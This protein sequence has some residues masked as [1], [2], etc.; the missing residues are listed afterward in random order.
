MKR[1]YILRFLVGI[2]VVATIKELS[3]Q[4][5]K[6]NEQF[7]PMKASQYLTKR[8]VEIEWEEV[9]G[10]T[11]YDLEIY[12]GKNKRFI[13]TFTSKTNVF[14]LNVKMG[15][16]YFRSRILDKFERSSEWTDLAELMIAP[17]PTKV[18]TKFPED[19]HL[20]ADKKSGLLSFPLSWE[21]LPGISDYQVVMQSPDGKIESEKSVTGTSTILNVPPGQH[22]FYVKAVLSDGTIGDKSDNTSTISVLGAKIQKPVLIH[23][24]TID[25]GHQAL[26]SSE[27]TLALFEGDLFYRA[28]EGTQWTKV[29][30]FQDLKENEINFDSEYIPGRY[31]LKLRATATGF[32]PS[33]YQEIQ[34]VIK[35]KEMTLVLIQNNLK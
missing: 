19:L 28:L 18:N 1:N 32:T 21:A 31:K 14:K 15:K 13:K 16:Y 20:F 5:K 22:Q 10:A 2:I 17:P 3:A 30:S 29:K 33:E 6:S 7:S 23:K 8:S 12:D 35:P 4:E 25:K 26:F 11:Q 9:P 27:L 34:F 24:K